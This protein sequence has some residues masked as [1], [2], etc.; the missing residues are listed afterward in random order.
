[1]A[2]LRPLWRSFALLLSAAAIAAG[3]AVE[4]LRANELADS[5]VKIRALAGDGS[6]TFGSG[7]VIATDLVATACHVTRGAKTIEI[8]HGVERRVIARESGSVTHDL[9]LVRVPDLGL[10]TVAIRA[11][12]SLHSGERVVAVGFPGGGD[13]A[14]HD[15]TVEGLYQFDGGNV[16]RTSATFDAGSSGGG[17]FDK[18]G[19]LVGLLAFKARSGAKLHFALPADWALPGTMVSALLRSLAYSTEH[20]AFWERPR[21]TQP[22][23]LGH[24]ILEAASQ[25]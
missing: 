2:H 16:I 24:A 4:P 8:I 25:R 21:A 3:A 23:F 18:E 22:S 7:V 19:A 14:V 9:C 1:M 12:S 13:L 10:P 17:L 20:V 6:E 15:G 5:L 11:S